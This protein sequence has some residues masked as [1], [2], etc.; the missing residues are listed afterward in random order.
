MPTAT[1][2]NATEIWETTTGGTVWVQVKDHR[3]PGAWRSMKVGGRG[4]SRLRITTEEREFNQELIPFENA[5]LDPFTNGTLVRTK[6]TRGE[7]ELS[8]EDIIEILQI[9]DD[10][11][12]NARV[13]AIGSEVLLRRLLKAGERHTNVLRLQELQEVVDTRY[14]VGKTS[15]VVKEMYED[16]ARYAD[17]DV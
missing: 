13:N 16:D 7:N 17:A 12:F 8:D 1:A 6:G 4:S 9:D 10:A 14:A 11:E 2:N 5:H 3:I 15:R